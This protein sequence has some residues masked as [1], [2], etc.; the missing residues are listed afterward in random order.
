MAAQS[1][2]DNYKGAGSSA[3]NGVS[4]EFHMSYEDFKKIKSIAYKSTGISLSDHKQNMI[5]G[6]LA[7]RLRVLGLTR[8]DEY[9]ELIQQQNN[10]ELNEFVN[11]ITTN[12]TAFFRENHHF[13]YLR[14]TLLPS[15][16]RSNASQRRIRIWSA[17]CSS[18]E[19]PHSIAMVLRSCAAI[20][21]WDVKILATDLDSNCVAT[22]DAGIYNLERVESVPSAYKKYIAKN[23]KT[24]QVRIRDDVRSLIRFRRLNLLERWPMK[25]PFDLIFCR[26]VVI[27]FDAQ[28]QKGLFDRYANI[29]SPNGHLFIGHSENL[30][31]VCDR[32]ESLGRTMYKRIT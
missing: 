4:R 31:K 2:F 1:N 17:G 27:Y 5:Y 18:G 11:A 32:F 22:G 30:N 8:F 7:R 3:G 14:D 25:G 6:R 13:E 12:L 28:T 19:E 24:E 26:N 21:S 9:C 15:L 16:I 29:L 20:Q 23:K 10:D